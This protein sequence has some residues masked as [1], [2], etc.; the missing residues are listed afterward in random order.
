MRN[1]N[2][3]PSAYPV[4]YPVANHTQ[5]DKPSAKQYAWLIFIRQI[6]RL[7]KLPRHDAVIEIFA[8][9][10]VKVIV[11][12]LLAGF[13]HVYLVSEAT[14]LAA[15]QVSTVSGFWLTN[16]IDALPY[17]ETDNTVLKFLTFFLGSYLL[18]WIGSA[19]F[20]ALDN[21]QV[22]TGKKLRRK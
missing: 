3:S 17:L 2:L 19:L 4:S 21:L 22:M 10:P 16:L 18:V 7:M 9:T 1:F 5:L 8:P 6:P 11:A 15:E 14:Q 12:I 20:T 13:T